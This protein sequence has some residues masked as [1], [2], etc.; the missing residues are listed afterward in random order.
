MTAALPPALNMAIAR[1]HPAN[2]ASI[3]VMINESS[4]RL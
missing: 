3:T 4:F 2:V 1:W